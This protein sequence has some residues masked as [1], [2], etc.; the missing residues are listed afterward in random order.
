MLLND[1]LYMAKRVSRYGGAP[2]ITGPAAAQDGPTID[3]LAFTNARRKRI[4]RK[5]GSWPWFVE[6]ISFPVVPGTVTYSVTAKSG[7]KIDRIQN[8]IPND[9]TVIPPV[10]GLPLKR[11]TER[12]FFIDIR[13]YYQSPTPQGPAGPTFIAIPDRYYN[14]GQVNGLWQIRLWPSPSQ[15]FTMGGSAKGVLNTFLI[16][17]VT[18][19]PPFSAGNVAQAINPPL[20]YFPDGVIEDILLEGVW[21]DIKRTMGDEAGGNLLNSSFEAKIKLLAAEEADAARDNT[22]MTRP[23]PALVRRRMARRGRRG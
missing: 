2:V 13:D 15:T 9:P 8:L 1:F 23:L 22:P 3:V 4:W 16:G 11:R 21:S 12:Q 19:V 18:G 5:P 6:Q 14:L 10:S 7:N 20:D 17:D